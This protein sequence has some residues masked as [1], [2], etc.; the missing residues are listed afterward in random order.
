MIRTINGAVLELKKQDPN[1]PI[2]AGMLRRWIRAGQLPAIMSGNKYLLNM[3]TVNEFL[4]GTL[5]R[6]ETQN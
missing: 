5:K 6:D 3:E 4:K 1:T 2:S